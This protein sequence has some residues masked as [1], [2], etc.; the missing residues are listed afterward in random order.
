LDWEPASDH[1]Q[2][3]VPQGLGSGCE[4]L[5][6]QEQSGGSPGSPWLRLGHSRCR[7]APRCPP[8]GAAPSPP[9]PVSRKLLVHSMAFFG[10]ESCRFAASPKGGVI[11]PSAINTAPPGAHHPASPGGAHASRGPVRCPLFLPRPDGWVGG[12]AGAAASWG[13]VTASQDLRFRR[14]PR[15][16][17]DQRWPEPHPR[18]S[19]PGSES[20][21]PCLN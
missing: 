13:Q 11:E 3:D 20:Q 7:C 15:D 19:E 12:W 2:R 8:S 18:A 17:W 14:S 9:L 10:R 16:S 21:G 4:P 1:L 5:G 6:S